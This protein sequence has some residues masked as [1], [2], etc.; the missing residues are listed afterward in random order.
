M[1][2]ETVLYK[3]DGAI[4]TITLNRPEKRNAFNAQL[5]KD[6]SEALTN[7]ENDGAVKVII[8]AAEGQVFSAGADL[9]Y[10]Q[11]LQQNTH[12]ENII[13]STNLM[14][15][16]RQMY[17][18]SKIIIACIEGSAIAGGCGLASVCD[19]SFAVPEAKFGYTEVR[20]GFIPAIVMVF[21]LRKISE[22]NAKELL[23]TGKLIDA[24]KAKEMGLIN[25]VI[26]P[27]D[28][29]KAV[30]GFAH[31]LITNCSRESL[32]NTKQMIAHV[33]ELDLDSALRHAVEMNVRSRE[34][35]DCKQG[36]QNFLEKKKP[37]WK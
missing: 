32:K 5:V 4:C 15:L 3:T 9:A 19:F 10:L 14:A 35:D 30:T 2:Y 13:D 16:Y 11:S 24:I 26:P 25:E 36:I 18:F 34:S 28:I 27:G 33:Q 37:D 6:I 29:R 22:R 8:L 20:I 21:L 7:A 1:T 31:E 12:E 23:L 17:T